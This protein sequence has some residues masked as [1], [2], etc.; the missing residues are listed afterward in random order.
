MSRPD[1]F[2]DKCRV[3]G[4]VVNEAPYYKGTY[5][6][7][8][9][10][11]LCDAHKGHKESEQT[12]KIGG[13]SMKATIKLSAKDVEEIVTLHLKTNGFKVERVSSKVGTVGDERYPHTG[14]IG[15]EAEVELK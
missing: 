9:D 5:D 7:N 3:C 13:K 6:K 4:K 14:F 12:Q 8:S 1:L 15:I 10:T 2:D 11:W